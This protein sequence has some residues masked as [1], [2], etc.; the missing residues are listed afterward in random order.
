ML[1]MASPLLAAKGFDLVE[2]VVI[3]YM[4]VVCLGVTRGLLEKW[5]TH[6]NENYY[7]GNRVCS[8]YICRM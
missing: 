6:R 5:L 8:N 3:D 4:H 2:G 7:I 1:A